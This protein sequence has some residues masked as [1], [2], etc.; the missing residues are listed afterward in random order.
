M[1]HI[2]TTN[3]GCF[4]LTTIAQAEGTAPFS[5]NLSS[6]LNAVCYLPCS[7]YAS[8]IVVDGRIIFDPHV[9]TVLTPNAIFIEKRNERA[10]IVSLPDGEDHAIHLN[11]PLHVNDLFIASELEATASTTHLQDYAHVV[12]DKIVI[13]KHSPYAGC[14]LQMKRRTVEYAGLPIGS[15]LQNNG[16]QFDEDNNF[17]FQFAC[18][19]VFVK[20][21]YCRKDAVRIRKNHVVKITDK[22]CRTKNVILANTDEGQLISSAKKR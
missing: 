13:T 2:Q 9:Y 3:T 10:H 4:P 14:I 22:G 16:T 1:F 20:S 19:D 12:D 15:S 5:D 18:K 17:Y 8:E 21:L 6:V 7:V 11:K